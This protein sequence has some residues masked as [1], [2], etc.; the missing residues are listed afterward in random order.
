MRLTGAQAIIKAL[1]MEN[2]DIILVIPVR[3]FLRFMMHY[4]ILPSSMCLPEMSKVQRMLQVDMRVS[5]VE[6]ACAFPHPD[7]ALPIL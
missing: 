3:L 6:Q 2:V 4:W 5:P 1:E 7:P